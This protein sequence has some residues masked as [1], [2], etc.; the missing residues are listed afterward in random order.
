M[1]EH[2]AELARLSGDEFAVLLPDT[3]ADEAVPLAQRILRAFE[4]PLTLDDHTVDLSAG[5]GVA[6][7]PDHGDDPDL[8]L[9][10]AEIAMYV[11]KR[12]QAG[13]ESLL[14]E[15]PFEGVDGCP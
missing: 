2:S 7:A 11:A 10:R 6:C 3:S 8:L 1:T 4:T 13:N 9:S 15:G 12:Q 5:I 14:H